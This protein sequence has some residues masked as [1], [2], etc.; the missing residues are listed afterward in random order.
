MCQLEDSSMSTSMIPSTC[1][2][3]PM[4]FLSMFLFFLFFGGT[5][6]LKKRQANMFNPTCLFAGSRDGEGSSMGQKGR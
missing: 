2:E 6:G 4:L 1:I 5:Q 3:N